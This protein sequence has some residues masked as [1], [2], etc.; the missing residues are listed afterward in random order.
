MYNLAEFR[1][2]RQRL[3]DV[4]P[5]GALLA[6]GVMALKDGSFLSAI[7]FRG[8]DVDSATLAERVQ[9]TARLNQ[10]FTAFG[11]GWAIYVESR[12]RRAAHYPGTACEDP[13]ALMLD[14]ERRLNF[15]AVPTFESD[16]FITLQYLPETDRDRN[17]SDYIVE[18]EDG[19]Q[20]LDRRTDM[21]TF[22]KA[23]TDFAVQLQSA[24]NDVERLDDDGLLTYLHSTISTSTHKIIAPDVPMYLDDYLCDRPFLPGLKPK[25]GDK[26]LRVLSVK[27]YPADVFPQIL[28]ELNTLPFEMRHMT[29][30]VM[31]SK[32]DATT[33]ISK[34][35]KKWYA[36]RKSFMAMIG[37]AF[38]NSESRF[39]NMEALYK[40]DQL[41]N[42]KAELGS[43]RV[44]YGYM[45]ITAVVA[46]EDADEADRQI[47]V[48][49]NVYRRAGFPCF[50]ETINATEA[51][52]SSLPG[53][54]RA[55]VRR[56]LL[57]TVSLSRIIPTSGIWAGSGN[58]HLGGPP[59]FRAV[60]DG[61]TP[62]DLSTHYGDV[63]HMMVVGPTGAGKSTLLAFMGLSMLRYPDAR[64]IVFD[65]GASIRA[66][67]LG[68]GGR[69]SDIGSS[70]GPSFQPLRHVDQEDERIWARDWLLMILENQQ[71][72]ITPTIEDRVWDALSNLAESAPDLRTMTNFVTDVQDEDIRTALRPFSQ[73]GPFANLLDATTDDMD[74]GNWQAFE[75]EDIM[76]MGRATAP[77]LAYLFHLVEKQLDPS[78]P[79]MII[80][81][82]AWVFLD[83]AYFADI[84]REWLKVLR[85]LN[86]FV[87][88]ATQN[89]DDLASS[90]IG[91]VISGNVPTRIYLPNV[92]AQEPASAAF[93]S[94]QGLTERQI[95]II[96]TADY[97]RHYYM[98]SPNGDR[99]FE[100]GLSPTALAFCGASGDET[101]LMIKEIADD[102][103]ANGGNFA[104]T[105][106]RRIGL[107]DAAD[108]IDAANQEEKA[109]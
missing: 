84:I 93:Y 106:L 28:D 61:S 36:G 59:L 82:E 20:K 34:R 14:E 39:Q 109:A 37:E 79:T 52:L 43:G 32:D 56:P 69:Y 71:V 103:A 29:R 17:L 46:H 91:P 98:A 21:A 25:L 77:V 55:N 65:K 72:I 92:S 50:I 22:D 96:A 66:A 48:V 3:S 27:A 40:T 78:R 63:G 26:H 104:T 87:I 2:T 1:Q 83:N 11:E 9:L 89:I 10:Y 16:Y 23:V 33:E 108:L 24:M 30:F 73:D 105:Y 15:E 107:P 86:A 12:R 18:P 101:T 41:D 58:T 57:S 35:Q 70:D 8:P 6:P 64:V 13:L 51:W 49:E 67:T 94:A 54:A 99:L 19:E 81:D 53:E 68:V 90:K 42:A 5:W 47:N 31:M 76:K 7:R 4:L 75:M 80:L 95:E 88:F 85:K 44:A 100:L 38:F 97:K 74:I 45:T 60:T 62:F 102:C